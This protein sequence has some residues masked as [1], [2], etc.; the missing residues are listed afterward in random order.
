MKRR[1]LE[2]VH[3]GYKKVISKLMKDFEEREAKKDMDFKKFVNAIAR[4]Q[5]VSTLRSF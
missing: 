5:P 4:K 3:S 2:Q 1:D